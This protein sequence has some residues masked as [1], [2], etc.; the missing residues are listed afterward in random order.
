MK[1]FTKGRLRRVALFVVLNLLIPL[2]LM[3][4]VSVPAMAASGDGDTGLT[5][6]D[7]LTG[8]AIAL[9]IILIVK[10]ARSLLTEAKT[11]P[12]AGAKNPPVV[13][14]DSDLELMARVIYAEAR[15]EPYEGQVAVGAVILNRVKS[16]RFPNTIREVIYAPNQFTSVTNG[17][18]NNKPDESAYRAARDAMA[19]KDPS[20][21]A[22][23]FYNPKTARNMTFFNKLTI[24]NVIGN[25]VFAR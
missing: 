3:A 21:G 24:T 16:D 4:A 6:K 17:Q 5:E 13:N 7:A 12:D 22:F 19:G 11:E 25:H 15:G 20:R 9:G 23:Y 18:V 10:L 2:A 1:F 8:L 14:T